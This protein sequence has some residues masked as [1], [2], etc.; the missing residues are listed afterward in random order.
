MPQTFTILASM[1]LATCMSHAQDRPLADG[2]ST[3]TREQA[4][5]RSLDAIER[6]MAQAGLKPAFGTPEQPVW[7]QHDTNGENLAGILPGLGILADQLIVVGT[8]VDDNTAG[9]T[10]LM[11]IAKALANELANLESPRRGVLFIAFSGEG[12]GATQYTSRP[13][14]PITRHTLMLNIGK[15]DRIRVGHL[16]ISGAGTAVGLQDI[17]GPILETSTLQVTTEPSVTEP[18][19]HRAFYEAGV[20]VLFIT[21]AADQADSKP[22]SD[23]SSNLSQTNR[24]AS[25]RV[26]ARVVADVALRNQNL[27]YVPGQQPSASPSMNNMRV[28]FGIRPG[29][30][31]EGI[32]GV[33]VAGVTPNSPADFAGIK[34]GDHMIAWN[35]QELGDVRDWMAHLVRHEPGDVVTV[36]VMRQGQRQDIKVTLEGRGGV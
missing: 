22:P 14:A 5:A 9:T 4:S 23:E 34:E 2:R 29:N 36:T 1:T 15:V 32:L 6:G 27:A 26:L 13:I 8:S 12:L 7:R 31:E 24:A 21:H 16:N 20:P 28:R 11:D 18:G 3:E 25:A 10:L 33:P 30:Y 17:L 35:G 19:N